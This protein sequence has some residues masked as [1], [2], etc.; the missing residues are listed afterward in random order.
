M[1]QLLKRDLIHKAP[2]CCP[3]ISIIARKMPFYKCLLH[4]NRRLKNSVIF[5]SWI[6]FLKQCKSEKLIS[7]PI[8]DSDINSFLAQ[9]LARQAQ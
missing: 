8:V 4:T 2:F 1:P 3:L 6:T 9:G 5:L 7:S